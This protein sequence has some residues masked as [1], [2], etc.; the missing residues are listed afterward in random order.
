M[1]DILSPFASLSLTNAVFHVRIWY[2]RYYA[3]SHVPRR[4]AMQETAKPSLKDMSPT[5][6][7]KDFEGDIK[8]DAHN[9]QTKFSRSDARKELERRGKSIL[10]PLIDW[11]RPQ[12]DED[13][14]LPGEEI[15]LAWAM[16][17]NNI[18]N[19][20]DPRKSAPQ[21]LHDTAGWLAWAERFA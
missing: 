18:E 19:V 7:F 16:M 11:L 20:I 10:L 13:G 12:L 2:R 9:F 6:L 8:Y 17:L 5:E 4:N 1:W 14:R 3:S 15:R 21:S